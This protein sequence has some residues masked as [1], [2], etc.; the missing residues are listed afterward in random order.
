MYGNFIK[1]GNPGIKLKPEY[2]SIMKNASIPKIVMDD[3]SN[4]KEE[5]VKKIVQKSSE[6]NG[7]EENIEEVKINEEP[8]NLYDLFSD[9]KCYILPVFYKTILALKKAKKEFAIVFRSFDSNLGNVVY[10]FNKFC[11]GEHP[12]YNG[13]NNYP[14]ARFDG[15]K[16]TK[17]FIINPSHQGVIYRFQSNLEKIFMASGTLKRKSKTENLDDAYEIEDDRVKILKGDYEIFVS[18]MELFKEVEFLFVFNSKFLVLRNC[19]PR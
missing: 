6:N 4:Q 1:A 13:R 19:N 2:D 10:E 18:T 11:N 9:G 17:N 7:L 16:N 5:P 12:C 8:H 14:L 3:L 15:S